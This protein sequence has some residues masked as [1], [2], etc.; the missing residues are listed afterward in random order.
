MSR[1]AGPASGRPSGRSASSGKAGAR[2][3]APDT[4]PT[5]SLSI[6]YGVPADELPRWRLRRWVRRAVDGVAQ[7]A[8]A[9]SG[10][11]PSTARKPFKDVTLGLRLVDDSE[12]RTLNHSFRG[13]DYA[14]NVLT[15]EYGQDPQGCASGDIVLCLPVLYREA[16]EQGKPLLHH[17]AHLVVH[18][19]LHALGY[20][21]IDEDEAQEMESLEISI[22]KGMGLPDPYQS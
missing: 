19:V 15:F 8:R 22:L 6:Q 1:N 13:K 7:A 2:A 11:A 3:P 20:D 21:H 9:A 17:A 12:G 16:A 5:L 14:T 4:P 18:G 10:S